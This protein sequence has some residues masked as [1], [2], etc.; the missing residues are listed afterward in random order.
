M[1]GSIANQSTDEKPAPL[2]SYFD[3]A[4]TNRNDA[5]LMQ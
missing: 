1:A 5:E 2:L 3:G 4:G